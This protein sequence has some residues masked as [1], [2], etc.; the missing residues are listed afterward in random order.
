MKFSK[1][2]EDIV[3]EIYISSDKSKS[4]GDL[5]IRQLIHIASKVADD[6][7]VEAVNQVFKSSERMEASFLDQEIAGRILEERKPF[8]T[9][10]PEK[11]IKRCLNGW[12]KNIE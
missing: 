2:A 1:T 12:N 11:L 4:Y 3:T 9:I 5:R 8:T 6:I 10:H 7:P